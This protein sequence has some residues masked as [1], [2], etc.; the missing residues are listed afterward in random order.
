MILAET[1]SAARKGAGQ[2]A[3]DAARRFRRA[4]RDHG[5]AA[6]HHP[7]A[8]SA[9]ARIPAAQTTRRST[10]VAQ[11]PAWRVDDAARARRSCTSQPDARPSRLPPRR[12]PIRK[13]T[14]CRPAPS[15]RRRATSRS[16]Q[17]APIPEM[18]IP[19]VATKRELDMMKAL[20]DERR[21]GRLRRDGRRGRLSVGTMIELPRAALRPARSREWPS[22]SRSAP[23]T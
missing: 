17:A 12:S 18:M 11:A 2:A 21:E 9:A 15:S 23:T 14:R 1:R 13:S 7:P 16:G 4:V 19:L 3:A 10:E 6:G 22:S 5:R 8:R 20:V